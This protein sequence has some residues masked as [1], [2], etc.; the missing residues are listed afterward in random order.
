MPALF[1]SP[2]P[3]RA[4]S[5][6]AHAHHKPLSPHSRFLHN[7]NS[8]SLAQET[9]ISIHSKLFILRSSMSNHRQPPPSPPQPGPAYAHTPNWPPSSPPPPTLVFQLRVRC[10]ILLV[11]TSCSSCWV[12]PYCLPTLHRP[13]YILNGP[14]KLPSDPVSYT[15]TTAPPLPSLSLPLNTL[16][17][18]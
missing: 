7:L 18:R 4:D 1:H 8:L 2:P 12:H 15:S 16:Q 10:T 11:F 6:K 17:P 14:L 3:S 13:P 9:T 5:G